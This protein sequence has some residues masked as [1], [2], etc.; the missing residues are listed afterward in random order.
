MNKTV[1]VIGHKNPDTDSI[2]ASV[3]YAELK[4]RLGV[5][6][7]PVRAGK[8]NRET[9]FVLKYFGVEP[10]KLLDS[11]RTQVSDLDIDVVPPVSADI[12][13]RTAW[14][15]MQK[16][17]RKMLPVADENG[18]LLGIVTLSDITGSYMNA[19]E[20]NS[21]SVSG[22]PLRN[23]M[24]T[25]HAHFV[26]G[27]EKDFHFTGKVVIAAMSTKTMDPF[28]GKGDIV[29]AGDREDAQRRAV[30]TGACC[31]IL[32]CGAKV[33]P[34]IAAFAEQHNC[35]MLETSYDTFTAA[36][37]INQSMP[38]GCIMTRKG[39]LF[40][41]PD[42]Y[43]DNIRERML[44]TRFRSYPVVDSSGSILGFIS[45]YH[46]ITRRRKQ[47]ILLDHNELTQTIDGIEEADILEIID[48]HRLGG[49]E[50]GYP[51]SFHNEI[52]GST[53]TIIG[54]M[55]FDSGIVPPKRIAGILCAAILSDTINLR[56]PTSTYTDRAMAAKLANIAE[57]DI[58]TFADQ[59][60]RAGSS[61]AG[62]SPEEILKNDF[63]DYVMGSYKIGIGQI[64][65]YDLQSL[66]RLK[67]K[68]LGY[69]K[70]YRK[71]SG[72][73]LLL[74]M[75]TDIINEGSVVLFTGDSDE[76]VQNAFHPKPGADSVF[77]QGVVSRKKQIVPLLSNTVQS[78]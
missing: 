41:S 11:V 5:P 54:R 66:G 30:E 19:L 55:Y 36:R 71:A 14:N 39:I 13:I 18:R 15:I 27:N 78:M 74:L 34:D 26:T 70:T 2:C 12:S 32:T 49:M 48:H 37:L 38:V 56:S 60:F 45:R 73:T 64:N 1:Y 53:S 50:T 75:I 35:M 52:V 8:I 61:I 29:L 69:M 42:D 68:L 51:V 46:L 22:T 59:M 58:D 10:P 77:L 40:F 6:T 17:N 67:P 4:R 23:I 47:V 57:I 33:S 65:S 44:K 24:E 43:I 31:I 20:T 72:Y 28:L 3:A 76:L 25:V 9:E 63:K 62:M 16:N 21:L 7:I